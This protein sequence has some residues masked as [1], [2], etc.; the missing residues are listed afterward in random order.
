MD[1]RDSFASLDDYMALLENYN[2]E[3]ESA[4]ADL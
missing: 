4:F 2:N 1:I 3:E